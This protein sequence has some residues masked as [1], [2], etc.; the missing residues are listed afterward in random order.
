MDGMPGPERDI[1]RVP[2]VIKPI[3]WD[4]VADRLQ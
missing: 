2:C 3:C 1:L 4:E